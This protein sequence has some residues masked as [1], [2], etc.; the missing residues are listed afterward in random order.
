M[1]NRTYKQVLIDII[2]DS[3][4]QIQNVA[5]IGIWHSITMAAVLRACSI[6]ITTYWAVDFWQCSDRWMYRSEPPEFWDSLYFEACKLM[7][8]FPQ[9]HVLR[10]SSIEASK[11][12]INGYFDLVFID[13]DHSY[14]SVKADIKA[15]LP[16]V[17][18]GGFLTGHDYGGKHDSVK[19][20]VDEVIG[21]GNIEVAP[22][23]VWIKET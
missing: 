14:E 12:F 20:A 5:E 1:D 3:N 2:K 19:K 21:E 8:R 23:V 17:K 4:G 15:W 6:N 13:A 16:L 10:M 22:D 9:L 18:K 11:M 7:T